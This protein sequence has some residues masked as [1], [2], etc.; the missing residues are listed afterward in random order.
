MTLSKAI[1]SL[2]YR[3]YGLSGTALV[4]RVIVKLVARLDGGYM[5]SLTLRKIFRDHHGVDIGLYTWGGCFN[6]RNFG[7][8]VSIGRYSSVAM[9]ACAFTQNHPLEWKSTHEL[10]YNPKYKYCADDRV[11]YSPLR[12][13]ND[14]WMGEGSLIMP[15]VEEI[16]DGAVIA[17][18]AVVN[19]NV[20][21]YAIVAGNPAR[22]VRFR[23]SEEV[24]RM[25][26]ASRW[27]EQDIEQIN[28]HIEDFWGPF[29][30]THPHW[31]PAATGA[32]TPHPQPGSGWPRRPA[33]VP[34]SVLPG[35][36]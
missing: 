2:L 10:F 24:V 22:V 25:L 16:G 6:P 33:E 31:T 15:V 11:A 7:R 8:S 1:C 9:S 20:P 27:W 19:K 34:P 12:I 13:G 29:E 32:P 36:S 21:P 17:A 28:P 3:V 4:R 23:F 26:L 5:Y 35:A 14:V 18:G 30:P